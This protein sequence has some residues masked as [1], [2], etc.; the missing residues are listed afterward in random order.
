MNYGVRSSK[1]APQNTRIS[2][3]AFSPSSFPPGD[4]AIEPGPRE[5]PIPFDRRRRNLEEFG[6]IFNGQPAEI[7]QFDDSALLRIAGV[8]IFKREV[9]RDHIHFARLRDV[10]RFGKLYFPPASSTF[11]GLLLPDMID[12]DGA[13]QMR[14]QSEKLRSILEV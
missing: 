14:R 6:G 12:Q 9:K 10:E 5:I 2:L 11:D 3:L 4:F 8:Q 7:A 13:N 1:A